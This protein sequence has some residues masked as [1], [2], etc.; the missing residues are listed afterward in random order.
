MHSALALVTRTASKSGQDPLCRHV[1][2]ESGRRDHSSLPRSVLP[3][4]P[5]ARSRKSCSRSPHGR[6]LFLCPHR[7]RMG[8]LRF[9]LPRMAFEDGVSTTGS[10]TAGR[11][12][13]RTCD[14]VL[15]RNILHVPATPRRSNRTLLSATPTDALQARYRCERQEVSVGTVPRW[16]EL[17]R[18]LSDGATSG[19]IM[20]ASLATAGRKRG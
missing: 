17:E 11:H 7:T 10:S 1:L 20:R 6:M 13:C 14:A 5:P 15:A 12:R 2:P 9:T 3:P 19:S 16:E 4:A 18:V 8:E